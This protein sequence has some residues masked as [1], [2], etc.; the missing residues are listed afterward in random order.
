MDILGISIDTLS[1]TEILDRISGFLDDSAYH[2]I[3]TVN[4]EFI[5]L[6][7][8]DMAFRQ[9]L[10]DADLRIADGVG[11]ILALAA[12]RILGQ[13]GLFSS[14]TSTYE[15]E[16]REGFLKRLTRFPGADLMEEILKIANERHLSVYLAVR[17]DGLSSY[18]EVKAAIVKKYLNI[19][20]GGANI[21]I[22]DCRVQIADSKCVALQSEIKNL[23][24][25]IILCNFGA[26]EQEIFLAKLHDTGA[27]LGIGVGGSFDYLT[28]KIRRAPRWMRS[29]GLEWLWRLILQPRRFRR[30]WN[31][32]VVFPVRA[33]FSR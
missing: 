25:A 4:P 22:A 5:L 23:Q 13:V 12:S 6:A 2:R 31:A 10:L 11:I 32:V 33:F 29:L 24:S 14:S 28:G 21:D 16:G 17:A 8:K 15:G 27:H 3:A 19:T 9:S 30:I 7:E 20:I 18:E 1:R 26:P